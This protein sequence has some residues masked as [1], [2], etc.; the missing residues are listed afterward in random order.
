M[1]PSN[2]YRPKILKKNVSTERSPGKL[3]SENAGCRPHVFERDL[4]QEK[5]QANTGAREDNCWLKVGL[6]RETIQLQE[7]KNLTT[8]K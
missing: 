3:K 1:A 7:R 4:G 8:K 2:Y 5:S 6:A